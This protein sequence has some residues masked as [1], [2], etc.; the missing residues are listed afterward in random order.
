MK[1]KIITFLFISYVLFF[2][3]SHIIIKDKEISES[4]RRKLS[5]LPDIKEVTKAEYSNKLETY[6]LDHFPFRDNLRSI[7]ATYNYKILNKFDNNNKK[8]NEKDKV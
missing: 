2:S 8:K 6:L 7:K 1:N 5:A 3:I 4:E